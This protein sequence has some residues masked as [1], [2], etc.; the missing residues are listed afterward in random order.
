MTTTDSMTV[1]GDCDERF[2]QMRE[3]LATNLASGADCGASVAVV[4]Y[5]ELVVDMWGGYADEQCSIPWERDTITNVWS[6]TKTVMAL[7]TL[8]LVE[9]GELDYDAR[10]AKYWPEF[11]V[12]GKDDV[13]VR[14]LLS[15]TSGVSGWEQ[16]V[17]VAD[18]YDWEAS[19]ARLAAQ[20]P[21]WVPG[22]ASGYHAL[23]QGHLVGEVVRRIT[24]KKLGEF[25]RDELTGPLDIDF[26]IGLAEAEHGRVS[27][28]IPPPPLPFD[29]AT[30]DP[31]SV[32]VKTF[33]GPAP[34]ADA[35]W[36]PE[37]RMADIGAAN[38]HGNARSIALLQSIVSNDGVAPN[39][40]RYLSP[41]TI[42]QIFREQ[43]NGVDQ[44]LG[45][46]VRFGI[47]YALPSESSPHLPADRK[48]CY[49]GGWGGSS[50]VNVCDRNMTVAYMMNRMAEGL[51]GD[52]RAFDLVTAALAAV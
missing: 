13:R 38:G 8:L 30:L 41:A 39:G 12:N 47:G 43:S 29:L 6:S 40:E 25:L 31:E 15:H 17:A 35:A 52:M 18:I 3:I 42:D 33:T 48:I 36:T 9:R 46:P 49:W 24:G 44:V 20:A 11:A 23:N 51:L 22:E 2:G 37:W 19:T 4:L 7:C 1:H 34:G 14:H 5:G 50:I 10:V 27:N 26:H 32:V 16:P 28:V 21:W 45:L